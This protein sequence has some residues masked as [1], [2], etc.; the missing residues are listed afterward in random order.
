MLIPKC[1]RYLAQ[2]SIH[3]PAV[4][5]YPS[6]N[7]RRVPTLGGTPQ[8][9]HLIS[10]TFK[11]LMSS[12]ISNLGVLWNRVAFML[13]RNSCWYQS[14]FDIWHNIQ[15]IQYGRGSPAYVCTV[16]CGAVGYVRPRGSAARARSRTLMSCTFKFRC[17]VRYPLWWP[18]KLSCI[19]VDIKVFSIS[20]AI[21]NILSCQVFLP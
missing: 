9:K 1:F 5:A 15:Y 10:S 13:I 11:S 17:Q 2:Y 6:W 12:T 14:V 8:G 3:W 16:R 18:W 19:H 4:W 21:P 7:M 20:G